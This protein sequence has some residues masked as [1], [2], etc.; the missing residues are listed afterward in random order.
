MIIYVPYIQRV[1]G[2]RTIVLVRSERL[3]SNTNVILRHK[4]K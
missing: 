2:V 4:E 3:G 1:V